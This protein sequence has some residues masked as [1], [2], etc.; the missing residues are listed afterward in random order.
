VKPGDRTLEAPLE[1]LP[2]LLRAGAVLPLL[3]PDVDTL[4][5]YGAGSGAVRLRDR[6]RAMQLIALPR[7][8][9]KSPMLERESLSSIEGNRTW[10]LKVSGRA[11]RTYSLQ[12][13][14]LTLRRPF[15]PCAVALDGKRLRRSAWSHSAKTGVLKAAF[16]TKRGS[17]RVT[18]CR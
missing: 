7:G 13:S 15:R 10:R 11:R 9:T 12:A 18:R 1:Q 2:L 16:T 3:P 5:D 17:L 4:A 8:R 14:L 6:R